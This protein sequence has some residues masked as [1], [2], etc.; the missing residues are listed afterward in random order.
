MKHISFKD[1]IKSL[2]TSADKIAK[3][4]KKLGIKGVPYEEDRCPIANFLRK[5]G[6]KGVTAIEGHVFSDSDFV[7]MSRPIKAFIDRFD[8]GKYPELD[9]GATGR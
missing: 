3:K 8:N 6:F 5:K 2:G 1:T 7:K 4:L 9:A